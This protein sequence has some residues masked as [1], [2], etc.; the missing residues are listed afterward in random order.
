MP[1]VVPFVPLIASGIGLVGGLVTGNQQKKQNEKYIQS[2]DQQISQ[3]TQFADTLVSKVSRE[4]YNSQANQDVSAALKDVF[5]TMASRGMGRST[6]GLTAAAGASA[7]IRSGYGQQYLKDRMA[8]L[9]TA[10]GMY[11]G[12]SQTPRMGYDSDPYA[13]FRSGLGGIA[14]GA[15]YYQANGGLIKP[16]AAPAVTGS[17][18]A[19]GGVSYPP[20]SYGGSYGGSY[21]YKYGGN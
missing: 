1:A 11:A 4:E 15:A 7:Q 10:G 13:G 12:A 19:F 17:P 8:A 6:A 20:S 9:Q 2:Q 5:G 18:S 16:G 21:R 14:S 3:I